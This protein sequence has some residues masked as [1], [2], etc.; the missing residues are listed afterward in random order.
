[1]DKN[2]GIV[3]GLLFVLSLARSL[4]LRCYGYPAFDTHT[5]ERMLKENDS[6]RN[7]KPLP[8]HRGRVS[9]S[10]T[11]DLQSS[12]SFVFAGLPSV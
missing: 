3:P 4:P 9:E 5:I 7:E 10:Y 1:V 6:Q 8:Q 12:R 11:T 2:P